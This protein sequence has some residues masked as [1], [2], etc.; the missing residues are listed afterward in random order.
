MKKLLLFPFLFLL[1]SSSMSGQEI[2]PELLK[3][4]QRII[5]NNNAV[6][7]LKF[8]SI[9]NEI[10]LEELNYVARRVFSSLKSSYGT[11]FDL[12][13]D[14]ITTTNNVRNFWEFA[15]E[16]KGP[17]GNNPD[18]RY[19]GLEVLFD[20]L[21]GD[22]RDINNLLI[23]IEDSSR[24]FVYQTRDLTEAMRANLYF[25]R[26]LSKTYFSLIYD[27]GTV[28]ENYYEDWVPF[29]N[30]DDRNTI[31]NSGLDDLETAISLAESI[32][33]SEYEWLLL[34]SDYDINRE[35]FLKMVHSF[36]AKMLISFPTS[37]EESISASEV[38]DHAEAGLDEDFPHVVFLS[39]GYHLVDNYSDWS[40]FLINCSG[41]ISTCSGYLPTDVKVMHV[42]NPDYPTTY[43]IDYA[44]GTYAG[45][46]ANTS[47]DPRL[48]YF[49]YT[50]NAGY[51][52]SSRDPELYSNY[53]SK[54]LYAENDWWT[55]GNP[56]ILFPNAEL[57]YIK[58][59]AYGALGNIA[60]ANA[61]LQE[62]PY[63]NVAAD[64][65]PD[66]PSVQAG[67]M[68]ADGYAYNGSTISSYDELIQA[69]HKEY[70]V[71]I[72][73]LTSIGTHWFF[74]RR[75]GLLQEL[76]AELWPIPY[77]RWEGN[78]EEYTFGGLSAGS[79]HENSWHFSE[80]LPAPEGLKANIESSKVI[81][82]WDQYRYRIPLTS[83]RLSYD[84]LNINLSTTETEFVADGLDNNKTYL[85][86]LFASTEDNSSSAFV[87]ATPNIFGAP[88]TLEL[89]KDTQ[90]LVYR[91][92]TTSGHVLL[93]NYS[94]SDI[95][96]SSINLDLEYIDSTV[97]ENYI[98]FVTLSEE[99]AFTIPA[100]DTKDFVVSFNSSLWGSMPSIRLYLNVSSEEFY[101]LSIFP[102]YYN[103]LNNDAI[104]D[105]NYYF[106]APDSI[107]FGE[108]GINEKD[109]SYISL[110]NFNVRSMIIDTL[111]I[112]AFDESG[113]RFPSSF[114]SFS[115]HSPDSIILKP[116][117]T[118][119]TWLYADP[120]TSQAHEAYGYWGGDLWGPV[121]VGLRLITVS[122]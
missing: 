52:S 5:E 90:G 98:D 15:K 82:E 80:R 34:E 92:E 110:Q 10:E 121:S 56:V 59:E 16:P 66:L 45:Y 116:L 23:Q 41:D 96:I 120:T 28:I 57:Q 12:M 42:L 47:D 6:Q 26:G 69:L 24:I 89:E 32:Q 106:N 100:G 20:W 68:D 97:Y 76:S 22:Q 44:Q 9:S 48:G 102:P 17:L 55:E 63:G 7:H 50:T 101:P 40:S 46:S 72:G 70:S 67:Y 35:N 122:V 27:K 75:H 33:D 115:D 108:L 38:L 65:S 113:V 91:N 11:Q 43:P 54:R 84:G 2:P 21:I 83:L 25:L 14:Q 53:F 93:T 19:S 94:E 37:S 1:L 114:F 4:E 29:P 78:I 105:W 73:T 79:G 99:G 109:S 85:F 51:L 81:L 103:Q 13:T 111:Y 87:G 118:F 77:E 31:F 95:N 58:A 30:P 39:D 61:A 119:T 74:M 86:N 18:L 62:S 112:D 36:A 88:T 60:A 3:N 49:Q 8:K 64:F 104:T 117:E 71:E 107:S